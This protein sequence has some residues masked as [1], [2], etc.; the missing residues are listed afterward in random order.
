MAG[1]PKIA[2]VTGNL[3]AWDGRAQKIA[4]S[5]RA[6]GCDVT[7]IGRSSTGFREAFLL[8]EVNV[9]ELPPRASSGG[10]RQRHLVDLAMLLPLLDEL[11][12]DVVHAHGVETLGLAVA[13]K[14]RRKSAGQRVR[15]IYDAQ[16]HVAGVDRPDPTWRLAMLVEEHRHIADVDGVMTVSEPLAELLQERY[17]LRE[18]PVVVKNAPERSSRAAAS[19]DAF[20]DVRAECRLDPEVPLLVYSGAVAPARGLATVVAALTQLD[21]VHLAL[22]VAERHR[23]V[24]AL[25]RQ[26]VELGLRDWVHI[27]PYLAPDPVADYVGTATAGVIPLLHTPNHEVALCNKYLEFMH[28]RLPIIVSDVRLQAELTRRLG[29]GKVFRAAD[30]AS[31][32]ETAGDVLA[33]VDRWVA[34]Y[35]IPGLLDEHSWE[36]QRPALMTLYQGVSRLTPDVE[37]RAS[38]PGERRDREVAATGRNGPPTLTRRAPSLTIGPAN[39]AGQAWALAQALKR[40]WPELQTEG[41]TLGRDTPLRFHSDHVVTQKQWRSPGWHVE[42]RRHILRTHTHVLFEGALALTGQWSGNGYFTA[43]AAAFAEAGLS[44]GLVF[45]GADIRNPRRHRQ[46]YPDSPFADPHEQH[47]AAL[48]V[49]YDALLPLLEGFRGPCFVSTPDLLD[50]LPSARWLPI[51][52]DTDLWRQGRDVMRREKPI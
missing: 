23:Y 48:Q 3:V 22:Q 5:L 9:V 31:F 30:V 42:T 1:T 41:Y 44:V 29:N 32:V 46:L 21:G 43:D 26:A 24:T 15:V 47:T 36:A 52:V 40:R 27:V 33:D 10:W 17:G 49:R 38:P 8:G 4:R 50:F 35:D 28:S 14:L 7:L 45:H 16:E 12:P 37:V 13:G 34:A 39:M 25:E 51:T 2:M 18:K 11:E 19:G 6:A 20:L